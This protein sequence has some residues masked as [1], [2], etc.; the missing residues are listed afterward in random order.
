MSGRKAET[1]GP[2]ILTI[3]TLFLAGEATPADMHGWL[4]QAKATGEHRTAEGTLLLK[5]LWG[6]LTDPDI[7]PEWHAVAAHGAFP[8]IVISG[9]SGN[10][11]ILSVAA[12]VAGVTVTTAILPFLQTL[13]TQAGQHAFEAA[14]ATTRRLIRSDP[15]VAPSV[16]RRRQQVVVEDTAGGLRFVVPPDLPN[17]ALAALAAIDL[18]A[19]AA[20]AE[21]GVTA[22]IYWD[23][24]LRQWRRDG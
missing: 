16:H 4:D 24:A 22:T 18:E 5:E 12:A 10:T 2:D 14:R 7:A 11:G 19:L 3:Y 8:V 15:S 23:E 21:G 17:A 6:H 13:A 1:S 9:G 20:P